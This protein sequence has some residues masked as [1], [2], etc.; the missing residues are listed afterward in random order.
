M[1]NEIY[2]RAQMASIQSA[3]DGLANTDLNERMQRGGMKKRPPPPSGARPLPNPRKPGRD[4]FGKKR[5]MIR[6]MPK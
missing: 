3:A 4:K 5:P 1:T 2:S 6:T